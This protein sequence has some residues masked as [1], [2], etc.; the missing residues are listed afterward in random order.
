MTVSSIAGQASVYSVI[1]TC[2]VDDRFVLVR[3]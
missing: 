2:Q 1:K 3:A